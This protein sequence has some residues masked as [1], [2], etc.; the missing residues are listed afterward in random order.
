ME[1]YGFTSRPRH[2]EKRTREVLDDVYHYRDDS[3]YDDAEEDTEQ[4][5]EDE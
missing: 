2:A 5:D 3:G 1:T 4:E